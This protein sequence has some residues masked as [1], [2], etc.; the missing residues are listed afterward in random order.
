MQFVDLKAQYRAIRQDMDARIHRVLEHGQYILGPEVFELEAKLAARAGVRHCISC[1]SGTDALLLALLAV[2]V[3][4]GD[5]VITTPFTFFATGEMIALL[6]AVPVMADIEPDTYNLDPTRIEARIT[7]RTRAIMPVS[8][9]GQPAAMEEINL[10]AAQH[11]LPVIEDAAQ[12]FGATYRG[13]PSCG[14][15]TIGCTSFFPSK[16]LGGY[17]DGGACF[18]DDDT[19]AQTM[20]ELRN[21][22]QQRRYEHA[23]IGINGRLDTLQAAI[24]LA[25]LEVFDAE[26][27]ARDRAAQAYTHALAEVAL[28]GL[29]RTP[30]VRSWN[31]SAWAQYTLEVEDRESVV[32]ALAAEGVPTA[33]HYPVPMHRQPVFAGLGIGEGSLPVAEHAAA[34]VM[35]L[36]M[37]PYLGEE[38]IARVADAVSRAVQPVVAGR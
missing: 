2:G 28:S 5:E 22:G 25:K 1:A 14:L 31:T 29:V 21:H 33:V 9:Y 38:D 17:G 15:S 26:L 24:L 3:G 32:A 36:P 35:S 12:S 11:G 27:A 20:R 34:R 37:H 16:P 23:R 18:T 10:I 30:L 13:R 7:P 4:A 8:L 19:L 6:G